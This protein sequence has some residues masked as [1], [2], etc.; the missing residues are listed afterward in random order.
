MVLPLCSSLGES[1][2]FEEGVTGGAAAGDSA[3]TV[4]VAMPGASGGEGVEGALERS[5]GECRVDLLFGVLFV[6]DGA[7]SSAEETWAMLS[8]GWLAS[9][10]TKFMSG[11][12]GCFS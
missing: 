5:L 10:R 11:R 7:L 3:G 12:D 1:E 4:V 2:G 6:P 8:C 9:T